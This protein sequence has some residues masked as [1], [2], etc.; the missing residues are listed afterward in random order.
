MD[1]SLFW[2]HRARTSRG[3]LALW[4][5]VIVASVAL[6]GASLA[7]SAEDEALENAT[8]VPTAPAVEP[9]AHP[10]GGATGDFQGDGPCPAAQ[11]AARC[12][13]SNGFGCACAGLQAV[14][15]FDALGPASGLVD[16]LLDDRS[17]GP[18]ALRRPSRGA[19][20][21]FL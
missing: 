17:R 12:P 10:A 6:V 3:Q 15:V 4:L 13:A 19:L 14:L 2:E 21:R 5:A 20:L 11:Q 8:P 9:A 16:A 18:A 7:C 1:T